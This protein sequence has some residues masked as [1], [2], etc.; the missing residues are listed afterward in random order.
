V[1]VFPDT[2]RRL[3]GVLFYRSRVRRRTEGVLFR[4][5]QV[6][7]RRLF[8]RLREG[9]RQRADQARHETSAPRF[10]YDVLVFPIVDWH[11]R[12][13]R[14]QHLSVELAKMGA[15]VFYFC[16]RFLPSLCIYDPKLH[17]VA[18]NVFWTMLPGSIHPPDIYADI[19]SEL[20]VAAIAEGIQRVRELSQLFSRA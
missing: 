8:H 16:N 5:R 2:G 15:R 7:I 17:E 18:P 11:D 9:A 6:N 4:D 13:Q 12:F 3:F 19:P 20:Q 1:L 14:P 10:P